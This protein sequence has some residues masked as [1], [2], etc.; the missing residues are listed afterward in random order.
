[1]N[2]EQKT[3]KQLIEELRKLQRKVKRLEKSGEKRTENSAF[4]NDNAK[5]QT[6]KESIEHEKNYKALV[7]SSLD[8]IYVLQDGRLV[9]VNSAWEKLFGYQRKIACSKN[10]EFLKIMAPSCRA[11]I[12]SRLNDFEQN[13]LL[14]Q[15]YEFKGITIAGEIIDIEASMSSIT[16]NGRKAIQGIYRDIS[17]RKKII[18]ALKR[19]A[20]IFDNLNDAIIITDLEGSILNWNSA[21]TNM[22]GFTKEEVLDQ[23]ADFL[24]RKEVHLSLNQKI[25]DSIE[26]EGKWIGEVEFIR[27]D[28]SKRISETVVF[29]YFDS[30][31]EEIALVRVNRD[32]TERKKAQEDLQESKRRYEELA[33]LLP[34]TVFE[35]DLTGKIIF[36]NQASFKMFGYS[37]SDFEKGLNLFQ[38][39]SPN[40]IS[41][42][43]E[44]FQKRI[45]GEILDDEEYIAVRKDG[46]SFPILAFTETINENGKITGLRG[47]IIDITERK[48]IED[49]LRKLSRAVEQ[50]PSSIMITNIFGDIEYVNPRFSELTGY[51]QEEVVNQNPRLLKSGSTSSN[52]YKKLWELI[53][54]GKKWSGEFLNKKKNGELYWESASISPIIDSRGKIT[55]YLTIKE[56]ITEK[57][58]VE[59]ELILAKEKAEESDRL[60]SEFLAQMSHEIRS[61]IN[62]ILSYNSFLKEEL[63]DKLDSNLESSFTSIDSAGKRLLRTID[64]I[65][66]MAALQT[67][68]VSVQLDPTDISSIISGLIS[69]F[70]FSA[71]SK[72]IELSMINLSEGVKVPADDYVVGEIF[73]NLIGNAIKYTSSGKI[74]VKI[75]SDGNNRVFV[76]VI[77]TGIGISEEYL[78]KLFIPFSQEEMG[79]SRKYE[80]NGLGLALVKKYVDLLGA[81]IKVESKKGEG[82]TFTVIFHKE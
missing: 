72:N 31:G 78:P 27:K 15:R 7:E 54:N 64:L 82:S 70:E 63:E 29:P 45:N 51:K 28:S 43:S 34:Q 68:Y 30:N 80:G 65:L 62:V 44:N 41:L 71:K 21:A 48:Q 10:F 38:M 17:E 55:H 52:E 37:K 3:K 33:N 49:K 22:Y 69:E 73:Q 2:E 76:D 23:P 32:I 35:V 61:P 4:K 77:D 13:L 58:K 12:E 36:T 1:M 20:F 59:K 39:I 11:K 74:E 66:N 16:W 8:A 24:N 5:E 9:M 56:D 14:K 47:F 53:S 60:K 75:Y 40:Q 79:Y 81:E 6:A 50:S 25:I 46:S 26:K 18:D 19:E 67:G 42:A 57:K